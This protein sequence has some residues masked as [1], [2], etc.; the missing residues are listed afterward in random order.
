MILE[1]SWVKDCLAQGRVLDGNDEWG[2]YLT[3]D[4]GLPIVKEEVDDTH[5]S[6]T[7]SRSHN[8]QLSICNKKSPSN[9]PD[10]ACRSRDPSAGKY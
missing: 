4:D 8:S 9:S 7:Y 3:Q 2:G 6:V 1:H 10:Y 5:K